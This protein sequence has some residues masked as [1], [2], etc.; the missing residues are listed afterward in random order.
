MNKIRMILADDETVILNGI[1]KLVDWNALGIEIVGVF[2]DGRSAFE[3]IV[4]LKPDIAL[5]DISMPKMTGIDILKEIHSME[6]GTNIIFIS[7]FQ[8]FN[9]A[10][11]CS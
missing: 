5:L 3:G 10:K 1:Q 2:E 8:D 7:G 11:S 6:I 9:Y 4:R